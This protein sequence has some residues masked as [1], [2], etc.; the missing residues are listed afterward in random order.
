M[1]GNILLISVN[2]CR[3]PYPVFPLGLTHLAGA[4]K[5]QGY[6]VQIF[7][8]AV[9]NSSLEKV[10]QDFIPEYIGI[11][12]RNIDDVRID[13]TFFFVPDLESAVKRVR[14]VS[15]AP[16]I[17]GGSAFSLFPDRLLELTKADYGICGEAEDSLVMLLS[18]LVYSRPERF[19][20]SI[21]GLVYR[22]DNEIVINRCSP[23]NFVTD[24]PEIDSR[25]AGYYIESSSMLN[26]QTQRGC[27][28]TCCYCTY[29]LIEGER[30]RYRPA[31]IV[32]QDFLNAK[33]AGARYV[34]IVDSVFNTSAD[35]VSGICEEL[36]KADTGIE[37]G[38]FLRPAE[39]TDNLMELMV[40]AG[41]KHIEFGSDSFSDS[42]LESYEK[43]FTFEDIFES[44]ELARK[45]K[46]HYSHFLI[47]GGPG[48]TES[49]IKES[50]TNSNR[51]KKT[52]IFPFTGMRIYP[53]TSLCSRALQEG[54]IEEKDDL[55]KPF[56]Y[57]SPLIRKERIDELLLDFSR[58]STRWLIDTQKPET[59]AVTEQLR[60]MGVCGPLWEFLVS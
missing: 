45:N 8:L 27:P 51:L 22:N 2:Q 14:S 46:V 4:L 13:N 25:L 9:E 36:I 37:W 43:F 54:I 21:P 29:P 3:N 12:L 31:R 30:S 50:F 23:M 39:L 34:F 48:E 38:C 58:Q 59:A 7:D 1:P 53:G 33:K 32:A 6:S 5:K 55:L 11:S 57:I 49:T 35:H 17:L 10:I 52:A 19:L 42:V 26:V 56:F 15:N 18:K 16:I 28:Y 60:K 24:S 44:S 47:M 40:R 41:L 20:D